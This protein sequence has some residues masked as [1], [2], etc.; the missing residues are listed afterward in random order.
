MVAFGIEDTALCRLFLKRKQV[1]KECQKS[2]VA[3]D[4]A[5]I[6]SSQCRQMLLQCG[7][8]LTL[9]CKKW[10]QKGADSHHIVLACHEI[11]VYYLK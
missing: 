5:A 10:S 4:G 7:K 6:W 9:H 2:A 8:E 11:V 1:Q 3:V